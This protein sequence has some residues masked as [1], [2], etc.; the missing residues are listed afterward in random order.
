MG[1]RYMRIEGLQWDEARRFVRSVLVQNNDEVR[2]VS[3]R[4]TTARV[5]YTGQ[6]RVADWV[7]QVNGSGVLYT[8]KDQVTR[9]DPV[10]CGLFELALVAGML[11]AVLLCLR[12]FAGFDP[13]AFVPTIDSS[14]TLGT[15]FVTGL[16]CGMH[17]MGM[18]GALNLATAFG[19]TRRPVRGS[20]LYNLGRVLAYTLTGLV[21]G[22]LGSV[23]TVS[24]MLAGA[25]TV[26][27][28]VLMVAMA[29]GMAG[30]IQLPVFTRVRNPTRAGKGAFTVGL[31]NGLMPCGALQAM[32]IYALST[33][34]PWLGALSMLVF[35]LGT[36]P[37]MF[38]FGVAASLL[39]RG[40]W[41]AAVTKLAAGLMLLLALGMVGRG[42]T[43]MGMTAPEPAL[44]GADAGSFAVAAL[45]GGVQEVRT[46]LGA[47]S[48]GDVVVYEGVPARL[49]IHVEEGAL[50]GCNQTVLIDDFGVERALEVGDNVIEFTPTGVGDHAMTCWMYMIENTVRVVE[51]PAGA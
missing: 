33:G 40:A 34:S 42:L 23:L 17:C 2:D 15:L 35:G 36:V 9:H 16:L 22:A 27:A 4:G 13:F 49:C 12:E 20:V 28:G 47:H 21:A 7:G 30:V 41:K 43:A 32:Q 24:H 1:T 44:P 46:E 14:L 45:D 51:A 37:L 8:R 39:R 10:L 18:C 3:F 50:T 6:P 48:Y 19:G 31:L 26:A 25:V 5:R 11:A 29:L 38:A